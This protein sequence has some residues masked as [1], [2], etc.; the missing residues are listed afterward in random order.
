MII[1]RGRWVCQSF[2]SSQGQES[3]SHVRKFKPRKIIWSNFRVMRMIWRSDGSGRVIL[4]ASSGW[5]LSI[6]F[7]FVL[8]FWL[9]YLERSLLAVSR[10]TPI[11][12]RT[13]CK[14]IYCLNSYCF[15][16]IFRFLGMSI[17]I[18]SQISK[19]LEIANSLFIIV[20]NLGLFWDHRLC[21]LLEITNL[22][23]FVAI[24]L[25]VFSSSSFISTPIS[26]DYLATSFILSYLP[27]CLSLL[28][29][30]LLLF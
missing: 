30:S 27:A 29:I 7:L 6:V 10:Y 25:K 19:F 11:P 4:V 1:K 23:L 14:L 13:C 2:S 18:Q 24:S 3:L 15:A 20:V 22:F 26:I 12:Y 16:L 9:E 17:S 8:I 21:R 5:A 28:F